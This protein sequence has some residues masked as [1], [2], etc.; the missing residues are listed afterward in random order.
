MK[1]AVIVAN[2]TKQLILFSLQWSGGR[3]DFF[4]SI[5]TVVIHGNLELLDNYLQYLKT[6]ALEGKN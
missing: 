5:I 3:H 6:R 2:K 4:R 1:T